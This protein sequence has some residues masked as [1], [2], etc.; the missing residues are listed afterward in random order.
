MRRIGLVLLAA[1]LMLA[2]PAV[3]AQPAARIGYLALN[4]DVNPRSMTPSGK[5]SVISATSKVATS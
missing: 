4:L 3:E 1:I 5:G 2:P